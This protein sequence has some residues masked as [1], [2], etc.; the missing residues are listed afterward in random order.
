[1]DWANHDGQHS[2]A[3]IGIVTCRKGKSYQLVGF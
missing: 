1:M 2:M 3:G